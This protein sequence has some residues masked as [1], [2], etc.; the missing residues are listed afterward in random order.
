MTLSLTARNLTLL[1]EWKNEKAEK[2][3]Q[4]VKS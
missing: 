4:A 2:A 3:E 1:V